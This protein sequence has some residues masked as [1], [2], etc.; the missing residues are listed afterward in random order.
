MIYCKRSKWFYEDLEGVKQKFNTQAE[1][2]E[3]SVIDKD[4]FIFGH[5]ED[6]LA[7]DVEWPEDTQYAGD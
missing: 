3:A 6:L 2:L 7:E 4:E 5:E 1:A